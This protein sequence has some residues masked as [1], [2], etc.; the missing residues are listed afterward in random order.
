MAFAVSNTDTSLMVAAG[1]FP[2]MS[3]DGGRTWKATA[4]IHY[5]V[6]DACIVGNTA[7]I[8]T[9]GGLQRT[10]DFGATMQDRSEGICAVEVW[11]FGQAPGT[12]VMTIGAYH[13][14]IFIRDD[15]VYDG[16]S[17]PGG[18]YAWSGADAMMAD[19]NPDNPLWLYAK[20]WSSVRARRSTNKAVLPALRELG[21]DLGY[22]PL[23]NVAFHPNK[24]YTLV[25]ADHSIPGIVRTHDNGD[26]WEVLKKVTTSITHVRVAERRPTT[27][28]VIADARV[29]R[30]DDDG[31]TWTDITPTPAQ[32]FNRRAIDIAFEPDNPDTMWMAFGG[33]QTNV[34]VLRSSDAG[35]TWQD[36]SGALK[37]ES[38]IC[39][40]VL[41]GS[42]EVLFAG[43]NRGVF[44]RSAADKDWAPF[45]AKL[46]TCQVNFLHIDA[47]DGILR[48]GTSRGIWELPLTIDRK[49]VAAIATSTDTLRCFNAEVVYTDRS[50]AQPAGTSWRQW[51]FPGG[52][53]PTSTLRQPRV[54]YPWPGTYDV[55]LAVGT[56]GSSDTTVLR[57]AITV[58][59]S[60]CDVVDPQPGGCVD[61]S[62]PADFA[63]LG[64]FLGTTNN[65]TFTAWVKPNGIQPNFSAI[66]CT[67]ELDGY[68]GEIGMQI[69]ADSNE[70]GY[71]WKDGRW[72][73]RSG[74]R[75][76]PDQWN[77]VAL[78]VDEKGASVMVNGVLAR[79]EVNL[80]AQ[81][82]GKLAF[83]LGTYHYWDNRNLNAQIDEVRLYYV[84][85]APNEVHRRMHHPENADTNELMGWYQF[86]E[87]G[88]GEMFDAIGKQHGS[89]SGG[90]RRV[91]S[92][93][94]Y[95]PGS[96]WMS[97]PPVTSIP[98]YDALGIDAQFEQTVPDSVAML[99]RINRVAPGAVMQTVLQPVYFCLQSTQVQPLTTS[100]LGF[101][102]EGLIGWADALSRRYHLW[103]R[104]AYNM[105]AA[106]TE[107]QG[108]SQYN[109]VSR[110]LAFRATEPLDARALFCITVEGGPVGVEVP[111][112]PAQ[113]SCHPQPAS[114]VLTV[115]SSE[116]LGA[117]ILADVMGRVLWSRL[118]EGNRCS[119]D[120]RWLPVGAYALLHAGGAL[121][122]RIVR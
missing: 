44:V 51:S 1:I 5:D 78:M 38:V 120:V 2:Y 24:S 97:Q 40:A 31:S 80:P 117:L 100:F 46:P 89:V 4:P 79:D 95:G 73:W 74:L 20:P 56:S 55:H 119:I 81:D 99:T 60:E 91:A 7:W 26:N 9:D 11:G 84:T 76:K 43:T 59:P 109:G 63:S 103:Q 101:Q 71:L 33:G 107:V 61:L 114:D 66:L 62:S 88:G 68:K 113:L 77:H 69:V 70:V 41:R 108:A 106:W 23:S 121:P 72:W 49:P 22:I 39:L 48:A 15:A 82:L 52:E 36:L 65:F 90:A 45:G 27:M 96:T 105:D 102:M 13:L 17:L 92:T 87:S 19:V 85:L 3:R 57:N 6:Q 67:D 110:R 32:T 34:K 10:D 29:W 93:I 98:L 21:I 112:A 116:P 14:P 30:S 50:A 16:R 53:P 118:E 94:P 37:T 47:V 35:S 75:L 104:P 115:T 28:A 8:A 18:W 25:A 12:G 58:L 86:N 83:T 42:D 64:T 122:V 54:R 111:A